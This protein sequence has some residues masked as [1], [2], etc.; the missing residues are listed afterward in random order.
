MREVKKRKELFR[1]VKVMVINM[2]KLCWTKGKNEDSWNECAVIPYRHK[3]TSTCD[4]A[5]M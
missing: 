4:S 2:T 1:N 5:G 3:C